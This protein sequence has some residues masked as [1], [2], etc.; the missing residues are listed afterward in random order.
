[1]YF[2]GANGEDNQYALAIRS[3]GDIIQVEYRKI[4]SED[5]TENILTFN[6]LV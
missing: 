1:M 5:F 4:I 2:K 6:S 3:V